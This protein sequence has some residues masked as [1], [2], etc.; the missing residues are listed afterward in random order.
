MPPFDLAALPQPLPAYFASLDRRTL[1]E[2]FTGDAVVYDEGQTLS[3]PQAI[4]NW[5][6]RVETN[7]RPRYQVVS[8]QTVGSQSTVSFVV[9]GS[10]PAAPWRCGRPL[11]RVMERSS[12]WKRCDGS[13]SYRHSFGCLAHTGFITGPDPEQSMAES[14][15]LP[16]CGFVHHH[17]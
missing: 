6:E 7:Y 9:S 10:S 1:A 14:S 15:E 5:L 16:E 17:G 11:S 3:E 13:V 4:A 2:L 12:S 8:A